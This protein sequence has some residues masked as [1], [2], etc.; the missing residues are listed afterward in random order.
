MIN[1][2]KKNNSNGVSTS[3][4]LIE[5]LVVFIPGSHV[6]AFRASIVS[7]LLSLKLLKH[8]ASEFLA[9]ILSV[10]GRGEGGGGGGRERAGAKLGPLAVRS[11]L[12][13]TQPSIIYSSG[14]RS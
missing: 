14:T 1:R 8:S 11:V 4:I 3:A 13:T 7:I 5:W 2:K 9:D 12:P 10:W 6:S